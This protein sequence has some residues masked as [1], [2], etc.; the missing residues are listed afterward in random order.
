VTWQ[1][2]RHVATLEE[3]EKMAKL[4]V[5]PPPKRRSDVVSGEL[6]QLI[7]R[8][9]EGGMSYALIA[10]LLDQ[11]GIATARC[12]VWR[13]VTIRHIVETEQRARAS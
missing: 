7:V 13:P 6:R 10:A 1:A 8:L 9:H 11:G 3:A 5:P 4:E 2:R 12:G